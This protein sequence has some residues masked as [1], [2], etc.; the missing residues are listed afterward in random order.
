M[1][2]LLGELPKEILERARLILS[3]NNYHE[4]TID[5]E[6]QAY[7]ST[8]LNLLRGIKNIDIFANSFQKLFEKYND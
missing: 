7:M 8:G 4:S 6:I 1:D 5:D 2:V 3:R